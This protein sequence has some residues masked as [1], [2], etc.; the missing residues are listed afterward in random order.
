MLLIGEAVGESTLYTF[1]KAGYPLRGTI[2]VGANEGQ[3]VYWYAAHRLLPLIC[4]EPHPVAYQQLIEKNREWADDVEFVQCALGS[5]DGTLTLKVPLDGDTQRTSRYDPLHL[6]GHDWT[7]VPMAELVDVPV[8]RFD[9][10]AKEND[11]F[12]PAY[13]TLSIDVQG[14]EMEVLEGFGD[15]L[16]G[17]EF[18]CVEMSERP[19][20]DGEVPA[21]DVIAW[22]AERG[23]QRETPIEEHNDVLLRRR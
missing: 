16:T 21:A 5:E 7:D 10:W 15:T 14:M 3:E 20:Y 11:V 6:D 12:L 8:R 13:N 2:H 18:L 23:F 1:T 22:L 4:F 19:V 17:F 9:S